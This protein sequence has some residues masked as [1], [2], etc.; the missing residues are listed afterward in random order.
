[1][2]APIT[3]LVV[4]GFPREDDRAQERSF[5]IAKV[6]SQNQIFRSLTYTCRIDNSVSIVRSRVIMLQKSALNSGHNNKSSKLTI[7]GLLTRLFLYSCATIALML[8]NYNFRCHCWQLQCNC[9]SEGLTYVGSMNRGQRAYYVK[10]GRFSTSI[11]DL[12]IG[13]STET[14]NY[15]YRI[16]SPM[17]PVQTVSQLAES[18]S[19]QNFVIMLGQPKKPDVRGYVGVVSA[20]AAEDSDESPT[21]SVLCQVDQPGT[22]PDT[23]PILTRAGLQCS[24]GSTR[25]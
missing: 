23:T 22:L 24:K 25:R 17:I 16:V 7:S 21:I 20:I 11:A 14:S 8:P 4:H 5:P 2:Y 6:I 15:S 13:I 3:K 19:F 18:T 12:G 9:Q 1:M 10:H